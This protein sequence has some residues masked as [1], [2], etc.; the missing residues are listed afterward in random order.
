MIE[1]IRPAARFDGI[2][3]SL[4]R[5]INALATPLSINLGI[6][7]PNV[8][9]DEELREMARQAVSVSWAYSANAGTLSLRKGIEAAEAPGY[10]PASEICVTAGTEEGLYAIMQAFVDP[11]DE[12]LVPDPGFLA[13]PVLAKLAGGVPVPY[14]LTTEWQVDEAE[15]R[16]RLSDRTRMIVV[17]SPSNPTGGVLSEASLQAIVRVAEER[18]LL[19]VADQ[20][21]H[22]IFY[23][24]PAP[25]LAGRSPNVIVVD[26]MSKSHAMTGLRLGWVAAREPL[27]KPILRAHQYIATCASVVSQ[28]L[29]ELVLSNV[30]WNR[31]WLDG[32]RSQFAAQRRTAVGAVEQSMHVPVEPPPGGAFYLFVPVPSCDTVSLAK[33]L[34]LEA[35][36]L[37]VPGV[38]FGL[39][40]EGYLR[41]SYAARHEDLE[42]GIEQIGRYL[43]RRE[44]VGG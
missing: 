40:G 37:T 27:M 23:G 7:E 6:G 21:Y 1:R 14:L 44:R 33:S 28:A 34:A 17:N 18:D 30:E 41:I 26:G 31:R 2:E 38:A 39:A 24:E 4:I 10:D 8:V 5:Q 3:I 11:G 19:V 42:S 12:V 32:V 22:E 29:G 43:D 9:P 20:V 36:V 25:T 15:L 13:Y 16:E 35:G